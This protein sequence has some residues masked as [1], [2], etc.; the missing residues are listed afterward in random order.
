MRFCCCGS[1]CK[2]S[3]AV[4]LIHFLLTGLVFYLLTVSER[5]GEGEWG[6]G[7]VAGGY[8]VRFH[9]FLMLK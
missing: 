8:R 1:L 5:T 6:I 7:V 4:R 3:N 9:T 2:V